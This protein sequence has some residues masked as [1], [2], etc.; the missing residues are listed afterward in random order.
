MQTQAAGSLPSLHQAGRVL[1][2][3][4]ARPSE[5]GPWHAQCLEEDAPSVIPTDA[6]RVLTL[7]GSRKLIKVRTHLETGVPGTPSLW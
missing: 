5:G 2:A 3:W 1:V 6:L 7:S 4:D